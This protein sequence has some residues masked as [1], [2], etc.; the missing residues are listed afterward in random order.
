LAVLTLWAACIKKPE[1]CGKWH[2]DGPAVEA[3][4][5][6]EP[7]VSVAKIKPK[8]KPKP[9]PQPQPSPVCNICQSNLSQCRQRCGD[10]PECRQR[11]ICTEKDCYKCN[12]PSS[13]KCPNVIWDA[14][15]NNI[16]TRDEASPAFHPSG[17]AESLSGAM[18]RG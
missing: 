18:Q 13:R 5:V 1:D 8:P 3:P 4:S 10:G 16:E 2:L 14:T 7:Q 11:C 6:D 15:S 9:N 12:E 17:K